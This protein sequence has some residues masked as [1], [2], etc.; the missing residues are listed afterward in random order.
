MPSQTID[1]H[2]QSDTVRAT[3]CYRPLVAARWPCGTELSSSSPPLPLFRWLVDFSAR[4]LRGRTRFAPG[5]FE[6]RVVKAGNEENQHSLPVAIKHLSYEISVSSS[7]L[8]L[9]PRTSIW[10]TCEKWNIFYEKHLL[11]RLKHRN[12]VDFAIFHYIL[13]VHIQLPFIINYSAAI[14]CYFKLN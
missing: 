12:R 5:S 11:S 6:P 10:T 7:S 14:T 3:H 2:Y 4:R 1:T 9:F 13:E 8:T